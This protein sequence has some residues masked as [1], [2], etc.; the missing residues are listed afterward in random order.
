MGTDTLSLEGAARPE[1]P[2]YFGH[3]PRV[4]LSWLLKQPIWADDRSDIRPEQWAKM[5]ESQ[6]KEILAMVPNEPAR[7]MF[8]SNMDPQVA[9][10]KAVLGDLA[11][12][13][14]AKLG[15]IAERE[16]AR[17]AAAAPPEATK[18]E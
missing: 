1:E 17:Q 16:R 12:R 7:A 6:R 2:Q 9:A 4:T 15:E 14:G 18:G 8:L 3:Q 11:K 13:A 5:P 10:S